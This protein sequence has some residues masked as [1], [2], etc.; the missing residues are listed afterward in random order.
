MYKMREGR[1]W[2]VKVRGKQGTSHFEE[3]GKDRDKK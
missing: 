1:D 3:R 2:E